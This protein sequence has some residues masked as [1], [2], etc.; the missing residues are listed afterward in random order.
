MREGAWHPESGA[1]WAKM[2]VKWRCIRSC[3]LQAVVRLRRL[4]VGKER[5]SMFIQ[6]SVTGCLRCRLIMQEGLI[7]RQS[8]MSPCDSCRCFQT[9]LDNPDRPCSCEQYARTTARKVA[10]R[11]G[12]S[13]AHM[14]SPHCSAVASSLRAA[15]RTAGG[16]VIT[17]SVAAGVRGRCCAAA[18]VPASL[19]CMVESSQSR[20]TYASDSTC[21]SFCS[22]KGTC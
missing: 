10:S 14:N 11:T 13:G 19:A 8:A 5:C 17:R 22:T 12:R 16:S 1:A 4:L 18:A 2:G 21:T 9:C 20:M 3:R 15:R 6:K 7:E